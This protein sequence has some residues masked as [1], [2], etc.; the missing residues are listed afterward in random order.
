MDGSSAA[1]A[2]LVLR[3]VL[4]GLGEPRSVMRIQM[5]MDLLVWTPTVLLLMHTTHSVLAIWL[6]PPVNL[7]VTALLL[8]RRLHFAT[9]AR[10]NIVL[11]SAN[12]LDNDIR[13][14]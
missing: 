8:Y 4:N 6:T 12:A 5:F 3:G 11:P 14:R 2:R 9:S 13:S 1:H 7:A 10:R